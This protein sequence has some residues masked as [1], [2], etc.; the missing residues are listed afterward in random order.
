[1]QHNLGAST[2]LTESCLLPVFAIN[3]YSPHAVVYDH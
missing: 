3:Y 2:P 1:M